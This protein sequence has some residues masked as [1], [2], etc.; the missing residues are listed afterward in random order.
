MLYERR[1]DHFAGAGIEQRQHLSP[2]RVDAD[3]CAKMATVRDEMVMVMVMVM[4]IVTAMVMC[5]CN[6]Q[7][8]RQRSRIASFND[9]REGWRREL[10]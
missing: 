2:A 4:V 1:F 10:C 9:G 6:D 3:T 5:D 7:R 8:R